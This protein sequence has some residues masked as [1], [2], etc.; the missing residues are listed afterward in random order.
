MR[1]L[2]AKSS[3]EDLEFIAKTIE[4]GEIKAVIEKQY[5]LNKTIDAMRYVSKGHA[6]GK[7]VIKVI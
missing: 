4:N 2:F 5:P 7:V 3:Q 1:F 6:Q